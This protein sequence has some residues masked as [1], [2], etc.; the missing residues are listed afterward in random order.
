[1]PD[2]KMMKKRRNVLDRKVTRRQ[3][4]G[5]AVKVAGAAVAG[6][7]VGGVAGYFAKPVAPPTTITKTVPTTVR[8]TTT[9]TTTVT[10]MATV[11]P[12]VTGLAEQRRELAQKY[13]NAKPGERFLVGYVTWTVAQEAPKYDY[14]GVLQ[15]ADQ[16]GLDCRGIEIGTEALK[17]VEA[18]DSLIAAGAKGVIYWAPAISAM[19]EIVRII[20]ENKVFAAT[21]WCRDPKLMPG[22]RGPHWFEEFSHISDEMSFFAMTVLFEKMRKYGK[23][24]VLHTQ[25]SKTIAPDAESLINQGIAIAWERYPEMLLLGH[26]WGEWGYDAGRKAGEDALAVRTDYDALWGHCDDQAMGAASVFEERGIDIGPFVAGKDAIVAFTKLQ[27]EGKY[28]ITTL[29]E[30]QYYGGKRLADT[31]DAATGYSYPLK[32]EMIQ[33]PWVT[34]ILNMTDPKLKEENEELIKRSGLWWH[35]DFVVCDAAKWLDFVS[36]AEK[37]PAEKYPYDF[38]LMSIGKCQEEG[39]KYDRH[40]GVTLT[41]NDFY[42]VPLMPRYKVT[43]DRTS[44]KNFEEF[45]KQFGLTV[46]YFLDLSWDTWKDNMA[47][48]TEAEKAGLRLEPIWGGE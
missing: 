25:A 16:F 17:A 26:Y 40:A 18:T 34:T 21:S 38:R 45:R 39:L 47:K 24:K 13:A 44:G 15:A 7:V 43:D 12:T 23:T 10:S 27:A 14:Q 48:I 2:E 37:F 22:D 35:R 8:E 30:F 5:T 19:E 42:I 11:A 6:L 41:A 28:F 32:D 31:Y 36:I 9:K 29:T 20:E 3:A 1:M 4:V 33:A 46:K